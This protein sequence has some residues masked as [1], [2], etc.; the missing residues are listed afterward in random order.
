MAPRG[1]KSCMQRNETPKPILIFKNLHG[2]RYTLHNHTHTHT[3][4]RL[5]ALFPGLP[6]WAGTRKVKPIWILVKQETVSGNGISWAICKSTPCSR[7]I[8]VPA[9]HHSIPYIIID[10]N[11]GDHWLRGLQCRGIKFSHSPLT[12]MV[13]LTTH[14]Q[15]RTTVPV[16]DR[17]I[18]KQFKRIIEWISL[19]YRTKEHKLRLQILNLYIN[20]KHEP[21]PL[22]SFTC[23]SFHKKTLQFLKEHMIPITYIQPPMTTS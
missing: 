6:G 23:K 14:S 18:E 4:S 9:P 11:F 1:T 10:T 2:G 16:C 5:T 13:T 7:Q 21:F 3:H 17:L 8:T 22:D 15:T 12:S 20:L 19:K